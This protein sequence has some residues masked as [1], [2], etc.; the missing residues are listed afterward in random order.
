MAIQLYHKM[1]SRE[2]QR[3]NQLLIDNSTLLARSL[4]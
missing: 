1:Y 3:D 2:L 4:S